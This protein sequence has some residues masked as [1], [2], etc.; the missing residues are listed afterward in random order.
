MFYSGVIE[1]FYGRPWSAAQRIEM[2]DWIKAADMKL[3]AYA[4]KDDI[5]IRARW[6]ELYD[7]WESRSIANLAK[8]AKSKNVMLMGAISP[9]LD[10][11]HCDPGEVTTLKRKLQQL[12][13]LGMRSF[14]L[15]F[16]DVP[17]VLG[18]EDRKIF[19]TFAEAQAHVVNEV[20]GFVTELGS[21]RRLFFCPTEYCGRMAG[22]DVR[23]SAY[24]AEIGERLAP[25]IEIFWTGPEI[26]SEE[27]SAQS[28]RDLA[29]VI[30][31]KPVIWENF[32]ANDYDIRR[33][34]AG[35]LGGRK[36]DIVPE[37]R[38]FISNPN[39]E[40]E[41]NYSAV[42]TLGRF[43]ADPGYEEGQA[44]NASCRDWRQRFV[45]ASS[46]RQLEIEQVE[47]LADLL[48]QPFR[49]G[50]QSTAVVAET[51]RLLADPKTAGWDESVERIRHFLKRVSKLFDDLTEISNR[52]LFYTFQPY[53][54]ECR[55]ELLTTIHYLDWLATG[56][57]PGAR[58]PHQDHLPNTYRQGF[59]VALQH[60]FPRDER[61]H[62]SH[63]P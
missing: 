50:P 7:L 25:D 24:L 51:R 35:P 47:L 43:L 10:I 6:R 13:D 56:P 63:A 18:P 15:L 14:A 29:Q 61:G 27:I 49:L 46:N 20:Q 23:K 53:L 19:A 16:D 30:R 54:W 57:Q 60:L 26:V 33:V 55:E 44:L 37:I 40:F 12:D 3:F 32:H 62:Y 45:Y 11:R 9:C 28:L 2:L 8:E 39:N 36:T 31:R 4:P 58:F 21:D 52:D 41:A 34:Y 1:G 17:S 59:A 5:K 22:G 38:G 48:Y 42:H